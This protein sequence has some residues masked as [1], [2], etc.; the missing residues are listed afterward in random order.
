VAV[1]LGRATTAT[2]SDG[3]PLLGQ[4]SGGVGRAE[5]V[6]LT[7]EAVT[8]YRQL[9]AANPAHLP[10]L[11]MAL[12]NLGDQRLDAG[13]PWNADAAWASV[14]D[15]MPSSDVKAGLLLEKAQLATPVQAIDDVLA[16]L[17]LRPQPNASTLFDLHT[18]AGNCETTTATCSIGGGGTRGGFASRMAAAR[19]GHPRRGRRLAW[20]TTHPRTGA[21][22]PPRPRRRAGPARGPRRPRRARPGRSHPGPH[23]PV[24]PTPRRSG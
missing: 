14:L 24:P 11:A 4:C 2:A 7:V 1:L 18:R 19:R 21:G 16:A 12:T 3:W 6:T 22:L 13:L 20:H 15:L 5:A 10:N 17:A 9:A 23:R 8:F